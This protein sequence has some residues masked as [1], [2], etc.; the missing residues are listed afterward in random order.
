MNIQF[1]NE[2]GKT[3]DLIN[4]E[5]KSNGVQFVIRD[6]GTFSP[7][8]TIDHH[9]RN[10][11]GQAFVLPAFIPPDVK[12]SVA[13]V[14][15]TDQSVWPASVGQASAATLSA[16]PTSVAVA[17]NADSALLMISSTA[18]VAGFNETDNCNGVAQ[19]L[20]SATAQTSVVYTIKPIAPGTCITH[21]TDETGQT[22]AV[23]ITV[24]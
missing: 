17:H 4:F 24:Q 19:V 23:P 2:S 3:A 7:G 1:T 12:C 15:F 8:V 21:I 16:S 9:Y 22:I 18:S 14:R 20:V 10:G 11:A 6:V 5:V 13:S